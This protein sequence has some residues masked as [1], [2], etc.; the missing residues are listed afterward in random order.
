VLDGLRDSEV[1]SGFYTH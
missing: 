1:L